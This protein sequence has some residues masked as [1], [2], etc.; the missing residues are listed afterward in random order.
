VGAAILAAIIISVLYFGRDVFIPI[1]LAILLSFVLAPIVRTLQDWHTP[2]GFSIITVVLLAFLAMFA[3][4]GII[5][6]Q[7]TQLAG[8]LPHYQ[9]TIHAKIESL[10]ATSA[11]SGP[12][13]RAAKVLEDLG[14]EINKPVD[15]RLNARSMTR[16]PEQETEPVPVE[17]R[18]PPAGPL[19]GLSTLISPLLGPL[20]TTR[21]IFIFVLFVLLQREDLRN[22]VIKLAGSHDLH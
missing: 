10:R 14:G 12:L 22:R 18:Q 1:A 6:A 16:S 20:A 21:I 7:V 8:D 4:G 15:A 11:T 9:S 13:E 3:V 2:R 17:V 5:A 19:E